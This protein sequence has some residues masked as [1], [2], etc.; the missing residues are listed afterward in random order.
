MRCQ[1]LSIAIPCFNEE[2]TISCL[3]HRVLESEL[4]AS[5]G[6]EIIIVDDGSTD[7]TAKIV[8]K[9]VSDHP[10]ESIIFKKQLT[11]SGKGASVRRAMKEASGDFL[12]VQ[13]ADLEYDP[14]HYCAMIE[15]LLGNEADVVFGSRFLPE[16]RHVGSAPWGHTVANKVLSRVTSF[17]VGRNLTDMETCFKLVRMSLLR[18]I[19]LKEDGFGIEPELTIKLLRSLPD[20]RFAEVP[21]SYQPRSRE[22]GRKISW[23]DGVIAILCILKYGF[24]TARGFTT[25]AIDQRRG[26][27]VVRSSMSD[28]NS[29]TPHKVEIDKRRVTSNQ[30]F[31]LIELLAVIAI[32][33]MLVGLLLVGVQSAREAA[34]RNQCVN[35]LRS[36]A[37]AID[38][39]VTTHG[40][41]PTGGW[42]WGWRG[43]P[44]RGYSSRQ[45][46]GWAYN[47]L[48]FVEERAL[49]KYG[50]GLPSEVKRQALTE[51]L[52]TPIAMLRCPSRSSMPLIEFMA[53]GPPRNAIQLPMVAPTDYAA[54]SGDR[55]ESIHSGPTS[56]RQADTGEY[57]WS[58]DN[59]AASGIIFLASMTT[60]SQ[61]S[62]G[63]SKTYLVGEKRVS[64]SGEHDWGYDQSLYSGHDYDLGR[65]GNETLL[66]ARDGAAIEYDTFGSA[67]ASSYFVARADGGVQATSYGIAP[68]VHQRFCN[69]HDRGE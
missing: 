69:R 55:E 5:V 29:R 11:N 31:T 64:T 52:Q 65:W 19:S 12:I 37:L 35:N 48:D 39:H 50:Q 10:Q 14:S 66:P 53:T 54:N 21:I 1:T 18:R 25:D 45:P 7:E 51:L 9:L 38:V 34:R 13:D 47:I 56:I 57:A 41:Y 26:G 68:E 4:P 58:A 20:V 6:R 43:D 67:H 36:I 30:G 49:R 17:I 60:T 46:G 59:R 33:T 27:S 42:G 62:D 28:S 22:E 44:D 15:P 3:L 32:V 16:S 63:L 24:V 40:H 23:R 61:I 2:S 8:A